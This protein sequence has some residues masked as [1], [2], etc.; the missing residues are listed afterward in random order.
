MSGESVTYDEHRASLHSVP[1]RILYD[2]NGLLL[3]DKPYDVRMSG[4]FAVTM[5]KLVAHHAAACT[6][7]MSFHYCHQLD[8]ATSGVTAYA[9][10]EQLSSATHTLF[11]E[12]FTRKEYVAVLEGH[13][14]AIPR[15]PGVVDLP[16]VATTARA[17]CGA[18]AS[19]VE[20]LQAAPL[21]DFISSVKCVKRANR[22][23]LIPGLL[24]ARNARFWF[25]LWRKSASPP[26][27]TPTS[28]DATSELVRGF[29]WD[30]LKGV[31]KS[32]RASPIRNAGWFLQEEMCQPYT[33]PEDT[34]TTSVVQ[35]IIASDTWAAGLMDLCTL[36][37]ARDARRY[38]Q[39]KATM[40]ETAASG[41]EVD[42][43]ES[44]TALISSSSRILPHLLD[45]PRCSI[46]TK[47]SEVPDD[48]RMVIDDRGRVSRSLLANGDVSSVT[49]FACSNP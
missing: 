46:E 40:E 24:P 35:P 27:E 18:S 32:Q 26:A 47:I 21:E 1:L 41:G 49:L 11:Q 3:V 29:T 37:E 48:F 25:E 2:E 8:Y 17:A 7:R 19:S 20:V 16:T 31:A 14:T 34:F 22:K 10:N 28:T 43:K 42:A 23:G 45:R 6:S 4:D 15:L 36:A 13:V 30:E 44:T 39:D 12:R 33:P 9:A 5:D 38:Q